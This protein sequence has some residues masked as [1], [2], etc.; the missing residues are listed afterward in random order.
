MSSRLATATRLGFR[1]QRRRPLLIV[2]LIAVPFFFISRA[3]A[4]T[5]SDPRLVP[6][7]G[8][9]TVLSTMRDVHGA[10]M[11]GI[12]IAF[13]AGLCGLFIMQSALEA[14]RRL[15]VAGFRPLQAVAPRLIVLAAATGLVLAVSVAVTALSFSPRQWAPFVAAN[16]LI[17]LIYGSLGAV[18]GAVAG[19]L[20]GAYLMLFAP[21]LDLGI[22]Q[23]PM[24]G[25]GSPDAWAQVLPGYGPGR[26]LVD[27]SFA[28]NFHAWSEL[29]LSL[30]WLAAALGA[31]ALLLT[32]AL[33][34]GR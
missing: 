6:L 4:A 32:R 23:S 22:A 29:A 26:L 5:V 30:G 3:I 12:T 2:L 9:E 13:L 11:A 15:V 18:A 34:R 20:G 1:E 31:V 24:F 28:D 14:D 7:P 19:R 27:A 21:M 33:G 16:L 25:D 10:T 8:G 17:G